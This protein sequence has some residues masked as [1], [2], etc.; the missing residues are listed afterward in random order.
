LTDGD[1]ASCVGGKPLRSH[2]SACGSPGNTRVERSL[3]IMLNAFSVPM[4]DPVWLAASA[5]AAV[6]AL[7]AAKRSYA[8]AA[9][10]APP[11]RTGVRPARQAAQSA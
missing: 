1:G 5:P 9:S 7:L 10:S 4:V 2:D 3:Q 8:L 11:Y 6:T